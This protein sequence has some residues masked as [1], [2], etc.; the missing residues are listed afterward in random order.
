MF[1]ESQY[2]MNIDHLIYVF[3]SIFITLNVVI[4]LHL[5]LKMYSYNMLNPA[6]LSP[7]Q[8]LYC[9][10]FIVKFFS[11]LFQLWGFYMFWF[12]L[13]VTGYFWI[14]MKLQYQV[15]ILLYPANPEAWWDNNR[16][17]DVSF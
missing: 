3:Q 8:Q 15:F 4:L 2:T 11:T 17:F 7:D 9:Y 13:C 10:S 12:C 16:P 5:I 6:V 1:F 14:F